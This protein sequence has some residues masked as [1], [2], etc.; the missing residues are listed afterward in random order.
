MRYPSVMNDHGAMPIPLS[1]AKAEMFR[2]LGHPGRIRILELL[3]E[4]EHAVHELLDHVEIEASNLSA[5][6]GVLRR[7]GLVTSRRKATEVT[8]ALAVPEVRELLLAGR[9]VL[10]ELSP[11]D[12]VPADSSARR[13]GS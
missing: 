12:V 4:R 2:T 8:Y 6:L 7:I 3:C 10:G 5:Q 11:Q 1:Q 13:P 9:R